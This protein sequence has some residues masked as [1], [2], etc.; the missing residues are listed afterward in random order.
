[1]IWTCDPVADAAAYTEEQDRALARR[2][3]CAECGEHIQDEYMYVIDGKNIC[4]SCLED[5]REWID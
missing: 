4:P 3:V 1:M 5:Y 2:P